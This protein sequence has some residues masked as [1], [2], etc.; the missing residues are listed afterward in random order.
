MSKLIDGLL[1]FSA[2]SWVA[3]TKKTVNPADV[4]RK[5]FTGLPHT[6]GGRKIDFSFDELPLP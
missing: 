4:A 3:M 5:S 2:L 1:D 6:D